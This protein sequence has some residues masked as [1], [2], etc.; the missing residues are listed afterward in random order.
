HRRRRD[1]AQR[2]PG[3]CSQL[4]RTA[5]AA[6]AP[7]LSADRFACGGGRHQLPPL[8]L[9][10]R[11]RRSARRRSSGH[12]RFA[13]PGPAPGGRAQ[14]RRAADR[15]PRW[16]VRP[17]GVLR[18]A[19]GRR[20]C[21]AAVERGNARAPRKPG[22]GSR[23]LYRRRKNPGRARGLVGGLWVDGA[24]KSRFD[25]VYA[26]FIGGW[27]DFDQILREAKLLIMAGALASDLN[28]LAH[29]LTRVAEADRN[30]RDL[31]FNVLRRTVML[32]TA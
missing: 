5:C 2:A 24:A 22:A 13:P 18:S 17:Q 25:R 19:A 12:C 27:V 7:A 9:H 6:R 14:D 15:S 8:L 16:P 3:R 1:D 21:R 29:A 20:A 11:A 31:T 28:L 10:Q 30:T 4:R 32:Y 26:A 23:A